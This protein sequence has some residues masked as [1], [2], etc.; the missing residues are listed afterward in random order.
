[1]L[2]GEKCGEIVVG[3]GTK[4]DIIVVDDYKSVHVP[5]CFARGMT[6]ASLSWHKNIHIREDSFIMTR[7]EFLVL[8][9]AFAN[10]Q[11]EDDHF[12]EIK[13]PL[14]ELCRF[15]GAELKG[16]ANY[17]AWINTIHRL[18]AR[19]LNYVY[20]LNGVI[21]FAPYF[22]MC[23]VDPA[24]KV[25][26]IKLNPELAPFFL[27]LKDHKTVM[28]CGYMRQFSSIDACL[29]YLLA[30]SIRHG[31]FR[32]DVPLT[33]L[34]GMLGF[35]GDTKRFTNDVLLPAVN[36]INKRSDITIALQYT[37]EG[38]EIASVNFYVQNKS[39]QLMREMGI[40][41]GAKRIRRPKLTKEDRDEI[42][43]LSQQ[44]NYARPIRMNE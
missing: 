2:I 22:S 31:N 32:L 35:G 4:A 12:R 8:W 6:V 18:T 30:A 16:S 23:R 21:S 24:T 7:N 27:H 25:V 13:I 14:V 39:K 9:L 37:K 38:R 17:E 42:F 28:L 10:I 29:L 43:T 41:A 19:T 20:S 36:E 1:M 5:N 40:D 44:Q 11:Q 26:H 15:L 34:K 33:H 3:D